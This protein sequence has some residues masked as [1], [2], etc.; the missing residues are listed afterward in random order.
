MRKIIKYEVIS[1]ELS[2]GDIFK[3][4][5]TENDFAD[6]VNKKIED[7]FQPFGELRISVEP[8]GSAIFG[9]Y[10][11]T[12]LSQVMVLYENIEA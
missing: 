11:I 4:I 5:R 1:L 8:S 9:T 2:G 12:R 3:T 6:L 10:G 7:G